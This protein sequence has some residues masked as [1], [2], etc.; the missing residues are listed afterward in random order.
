MPGEMNKS[1]VLHVHEFVYV[2]MYVCVYVCV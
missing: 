2:R 1:D